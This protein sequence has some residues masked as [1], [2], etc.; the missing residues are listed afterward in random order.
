MFTKIQP[1]A[2]AMTILYSVIFSLNLVI[3]YIFEKFYKIYIFRVAALRLRKALFHR[4]IKSIFFFFFRLNP[5]ILA[6]LI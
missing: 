4:K 6:N 5:E 2:V 3:P 1:F